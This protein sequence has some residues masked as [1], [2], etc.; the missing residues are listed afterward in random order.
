MNLKKKRIKLS[1]HL[2]QLYQA[3]L[4]WCL[5][6]GLWLLLWLYLTIL[7]IL[8]KKKHLRF[9]NK[10]IYFKL[11]YFL[12]LD[13]EGY[14][15]IARLAIRDIVRPA[16]SLGMYIWR[17]DSLD[18]TCLKRPHLTFDGHAHLNIVALPTHRKKSPFIFASNFDLITFCWLSAIQ[19]QLRLS[20]G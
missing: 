4:T 10:T 17:R 6:I 19:F 9:L 1:L 11:N 18:P 3:R 2:Y 13:F 14:C 5:P 15:N 12:A 8:F 7:I 20:V 16:G